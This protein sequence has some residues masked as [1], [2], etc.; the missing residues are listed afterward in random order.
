MAAAVTMRLQ[1]LGLAN[2]QLV[3]VHPWV[4][5]HERFRAWP[6]ALFRDLIARLIAEPDVAV[7]LVGSKTE[8]PLAREHFDGLA[9]PRFRDLTGALTFAET[10]A[11]L[12][13]SRCLV[14]NDSCLIM[15]ADGLRVPSVAIFGSTAPVQVLAKSSIC[16]AIVTEANLACRPCYLHQTLFAYECDHQFRCLGEPSR[17]NVCCSMTRDPRRRSSLIAWTPGGSMRI[18]IDA[19]FLMHGVG[20]YAEE[21]LTHLAAIDDTHTFYV[22]T[23]TAYPQAPSL[24]RLAGDRL[25]EI[26]GRG[27]LYSLS[28]QYPASCTTSRDA[29]CSFSTQRRIHHRSSGSA[30]WL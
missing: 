28:G 25:E 9:S 15:V 3:V 21:L 6:P 20:R 26:P 7:V 16:Q 22:F 14:C 4:G 27:S 5:H 13:R 23:S 24:D 17:S 2:H 1:A 29:G 8:R 10:A 18:G 11:L 12:G 30:R 19:R